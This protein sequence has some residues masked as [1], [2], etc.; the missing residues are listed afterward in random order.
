ME[1][2]SVNRGRPFADQ[3]GKHEEVQ[4]FAD[5]AVVSLL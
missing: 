4:V 1:P 5:F 2:F 3:V